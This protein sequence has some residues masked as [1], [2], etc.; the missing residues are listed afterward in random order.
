[1]N[2][3]KNKFRW[4]RIA[5]Q[6]FLVCK[7]TW[8]SSRLY[9]GMDML[10]PYFLLLFFVFLPC[11]GKTKMKTPSCGSRAMQDWTWWACLWPWFSLLA[12]DDAGHALDYLPEKQPSSCIKPFSPEEKLKHQTWVSRFLNSPADLRVTV[13]FQHSLCSWLTLIQHCFH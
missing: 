2:L 11:R 10:C 8:S 12:P 5:C 4:K 7:L 13:L 1:M 9:I 6:D 3:A